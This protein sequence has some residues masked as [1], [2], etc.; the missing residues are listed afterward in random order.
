M[1]LWELSLNLR[2]WVLRLSLGSRKG[3]CRSKERRESAVGALEGR[4][5]VEI[6]EKGKGA[7]MRV[8]RVGW[9][10]EGWM[11]RRV[12]RADDVGERIGPLLGCGPGEGLRWRACELLCR[13]RDPLLR[14]GLDGERKLRESFLGFV[15]VVKP[16]GVLWCASLT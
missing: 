3:G 10:W 11:L 8:G 5:E 9:C 2:V 15:V 16:G 6:G 12:E 14:W 1:D 13:D 7:E 4:I